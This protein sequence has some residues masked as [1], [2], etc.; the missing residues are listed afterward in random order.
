[1]KITITTIIVGLLKSTGGVIIILSLLFVGCAQ[2]EN[3]SKKDIR[4]IRLGIASLQGGGHEDMPEYIRVFQIP[5]YRQELQWGT[6]EEQRGV[7]DFSFLQQR[8]AEIK[9]MN[10]KAIIKLNANLKPEWL[11]DVVPYAEELLGGGMEQNQIY[12]D[13]THRYSRFIEYCR[14]GKTHGF[15]EVDGYH[16]D[17]RRYDPDEIFKITQFN[18]WKFLSDM[19]CGISLAGM[20]F[21]DALFE[22]S[23]EKGGTVWEY[24]EWPELVEAWKFADKY[25]IVNVRS[26]EVIFHMLEVKRVNY[27][28]QNQS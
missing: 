7:Y 4:D 1:M 18:Y 15:V 28:S 19:H 3:R 22:G 6:V 23:L 17:A 16:N 13:G 9:G 5:S 21:E 2:N 10:R 8:L 14:T 27:P 25:E 12:F 11:F 26:D 20:H 24:F